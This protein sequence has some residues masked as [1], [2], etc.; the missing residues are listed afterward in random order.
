MQGFGNRRLGR[1][2]CRATEPQL[3]TQSQV[4]EGEVLPRTQSADHPPK[5]MPERHNH[6]M[7]LIGRV[8]I[9]L[10]DKSYTLRV[11]DVLARH[12]HRHRL[13]RKGQ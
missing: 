11:H 7:Y 3:V 6:G 9:E 8:R 12:N 5:E 13:D 2:A 10:F 4:F 1:C